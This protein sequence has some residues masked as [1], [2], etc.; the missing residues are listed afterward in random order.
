MIST[1]TWVERCIPLVNGVEI[2]MT[3]LIVSD[4]NLVQHCL[5][6]TA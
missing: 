1:S 6:M 2:I 5:E 3:C 4:R